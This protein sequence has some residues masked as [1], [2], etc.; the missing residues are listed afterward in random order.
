MLRRGPDGRP[1]RLQT[2]EQLDVMEQ[3][4]AA[5]EYVHEQGYIHADVKPENILVDGGLGHIILNDLGHAYSSSEE[6]H[7]WR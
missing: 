5:L 4:A 1:K 2:H 3:M 7:V 6:D